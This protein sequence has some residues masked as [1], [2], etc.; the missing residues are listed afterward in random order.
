MNIRTCLETDRACRPGLRRGISPEGNAPSGR[1]LGRCAAPFLALAFALAP[2]VGG[3]PA[4]G[5]LIPVPKE[6]SLSLQQQTRLERFKEDTAASTVD[7]VRLNLAPLPAANGIHVRIRPED[8][9]VYLRRAHVEH[10]SADEYSWFAAAPEP[11]AEGEG[12]HYDNKV[13]LLV[14]K[15]NAMGSL[16]LHGKRYSIRPLGEGLHAVIHLSSTAEDHL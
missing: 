4:D 11:N 6:Q 7:I 8:E 9:S 15:H 14:G 1:R 5:L 10:R 13:I 3:Q 12:A 2:Q 16:R